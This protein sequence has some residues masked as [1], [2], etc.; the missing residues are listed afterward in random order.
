MFLWTCTTSKVCTN[1]EGCAPTLRGQDSLFHHRLL[2]N[3]YNN[4]QN[5]QLFNKKKKKKKKKIKKKE[6]KKT[7][8]VITINEAQAL[9]YLFIYEAYEAKS[10]EML[11]E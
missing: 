2:Q 1:S 9:I 3:E 8:V 7:L 4:N 11:T 6:K 10:Q 5:Q